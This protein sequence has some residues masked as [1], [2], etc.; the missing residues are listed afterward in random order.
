MRAPDASATGPG[1]APRQ[2]RSV[3]GPGT[4]SALKQRNFRLYIGGQLISVSGTWMQGTAQAWLVLKTLHGRGVALSWVSTCTAV[5]MLLFGLWSGT[6]TDRFERRH[7]MIVTQTWMAAVAA[8]QAIL[9]ITG[10]VRLWMVLAL[11]FGMGLGTAFDMPTRH[12][13]LTEMVEP[14]D[15]TN[16]VGIQ[17]LVF[18]SGRVVGPALAAGV[19]KLVG[20]SWCF[21]LNALSF[22]AVIGG[23]LAM[24]TDQLRP[25]TRTPRSKRAVRE[26]LAYSWSVVDLRVSL[27]MV[28]IVGLFALNMNV[29]IPLF[30]REAFQGGEGWV[31]VLSACVG[32][33]AVGAALLTARRRRP[34][35]RLLIGAATAFGISFLGLAAAPGPWVGAVAATAVGLS[36]ITFMNAAN[37]TL[38]L[39]TDDQRRGR[40]M[41]TYSFLIIGTTPIGAP[42]VGRIAEHW[43][44]RVATAFMG[45]MVLV[46]ALLGRR[47]LSPRIRTDELPG[48]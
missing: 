3:E 36:F 4:F 17:S 16:A 21:A 28:A 8:L 37:T 45:I 22:L 15:L 27:I 43:N 26:G 24:R 34:T 23:L 46:A 12:V 47:M 48:P 29:V 25:H 1:R 18:N 44:V 32:L 14:D 10:V 2:S 38:Q 7:T 9:V 35:R 30:A 13:F 42:L 20:T 41:A 40:V 31:G 11:A 6:I 33:G 19:I 5:P 39:G